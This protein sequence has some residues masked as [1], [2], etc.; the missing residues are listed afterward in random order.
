M[1]LKDFFELVNYRIT[2]GSSYHWECYGRNAYYITAWDEKHDGVSAGIIFDT[3]TKVV[4]EV[5]VNDYSTEQA[6]RWI[7]LDFKSAYVEE[8]RTRGLDPNEAWEEVRWVDI[9]EEEAFFAKAT[10]VLRPLIV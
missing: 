4:Y 1:S 5:E 10:E 6:Y 3:S 9:N 8:C 2:E 7:N